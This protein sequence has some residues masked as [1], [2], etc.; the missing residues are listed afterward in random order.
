MTIAYALGVLGKSLFQIPIDR[1]AACNATIMSF[2]G[3]D[4]YLPMGQVIISYTFWYFIYCIIVNGFVIG[5]IGM[6]IFFSI[7]TLSDM[8]WN[9]YNNCFPLQSI[10]VALI[11]GA[12]LGLAAGAAIDAI[13]D[14]KYLYFFNGITGKSSAIDS[15]SAPSKQKFKCNVT[16]GGII[17]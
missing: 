17:P 8:A 9:K 14:R 3:S 16:Q 5:N 1:D 10:L 6:I 11:V 13:S 7:L 2:G 15:C 12:G 4:S